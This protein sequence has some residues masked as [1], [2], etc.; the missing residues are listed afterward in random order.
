[1]QNHNFH[2]HSLY[3]DG[4]YTLR[5]VA[6]AALDK[7]FT[8]LGFSDHS[9]ARVEED[10]CMTHEGEISY[11][12]KVRSLADEYGDRIKIYLGIEQDSESEIP[13]Y[14][15]DYIIS[16]VHEMARHGE[17]LPIDSSAELLK[18]LVDDLFGGSSDDF[19]KAY[20]DKV[21]D[22]VARNKTDIIGHFDLPTKFSTIPETDSYV[23][24]AIDAVHE[25]MKYCDLFELNTGAIARGLTVLPYPAGFI[26]DEIGKAGGRII[27]TS[28]CHYKE[29]LTVWFDKA[30]EY[31]M[32]YGF[33]ANDNGSINEKISGI[34]IW[35]SKK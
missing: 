33:T 15:Y 8:H 7:G 19:A 26:L 23:K 12:E 21:T 30:D 25:C 28:D 31:L 3:S 1:M 14:E 9:Y 5:E 35:E 17:S 4:K 34:R 32:S 16:S 29:K 2:T 27:V 11:R 18:K 22:N 10:Y 24:Y 20:F 13:D 6:D